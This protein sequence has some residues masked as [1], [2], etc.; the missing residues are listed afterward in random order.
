VQVFCVTPFIHNVI[1]FFEVVSARA[2]EERQKA[3]DNNFAEES[4]LDRM[5]WSH[6]SLRR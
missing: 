3:L 6:D 5:S 4:R 1:I 2:E